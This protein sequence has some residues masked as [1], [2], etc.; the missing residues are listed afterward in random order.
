[1]ISLFNGFKYCGFCIVKL[2]KYFSVKY[3]TKIRRYLDF[4]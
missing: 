4:R 1:M 3:N 2:L